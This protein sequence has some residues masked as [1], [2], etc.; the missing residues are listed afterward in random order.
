LKAP[1][2]KLQTPENLQIPSSKTITG[3]A[4][5]GFGAWTF[6]GAWCLGFGVSIAALLKKDASDQIAAP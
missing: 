2:T 5:V 4:S 1:N 3:Q 6:S